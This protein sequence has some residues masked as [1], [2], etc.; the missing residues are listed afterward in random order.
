MRCASACI[1]CAAHPDLGALEPEILE[2]AAQ[3][4]RISQDL[5]ETYSDEKVDRARTFLQQR[6]QEIDTFQ[7][8]DGSGQTGHG[9]VEKLGKIGRDRRKHGRQ[10]D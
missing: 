2:L 4:S 6:Q 8:P 9:R 3:M 10:P 1:I 5:A 7:R